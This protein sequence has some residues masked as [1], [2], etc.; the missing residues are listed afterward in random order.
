VAAMQ[1][2]DEKTARNTLTR[3]VKTMFPGGRI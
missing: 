3:I 2:A 1:S